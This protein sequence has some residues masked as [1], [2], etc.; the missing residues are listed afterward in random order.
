[1]I[2]RYSDDFLLPPWSVEGLEACFSVGCTVGPMAVAP[3]ATR[4][5]RLAYA[6]SEEWRASPSADDNIAQWNLSVASPDIAH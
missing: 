5:A 3:L 2:T 4:R 6:L 1:M